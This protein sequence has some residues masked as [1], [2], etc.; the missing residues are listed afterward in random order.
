[1]SHH[2]EA[3]LQEAP[4][5]EPCSPWKVY[6]LHPTFWAIVLEFQHVKIS[7]TRKGQQPDQGPR[8][9]QMQILPVC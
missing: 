5:S 6:T 2:I 3:F 8:A 9:W 7:A 4:S 1:M